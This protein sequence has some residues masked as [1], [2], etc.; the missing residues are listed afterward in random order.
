MIDTMG[1]RGEK[2]D[3]ERML[4]LWKTIYTTEPNTEI[5]DCFSMK[6]Q[7]YNI[8]NSTQF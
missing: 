6:A 7:P 8:S 4:G 2:V 5:S 3:P 1:T